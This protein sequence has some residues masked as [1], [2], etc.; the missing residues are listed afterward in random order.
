MIKNLTRR[1]FVVGASLAT[2]AFAAGTAL[3]DAAAPEGAPDAGGPGEGGAPGAGGPGGMGSADPI[4]LTGMLALKQYVFVASQ[5]EVTDG[6]V[7]CECFGAYGEG[8][9]VRFAPASFDGAIEVYLDAAKTQVAD[10]VTASV[11]DGT[12]T[13]EGVSGFGNVTYYLTTGEG[14]YTTVVY[15]VNDEYLTDAA[16]TLADGTSLE[17]SRYAPNMA[18]GDYTATVDAVN[19]AGAVYIGGNRMIRTAADYGIEGDDAAAVD[20]F[21]SSGVTNAGDTLTEFGEKMYGFEYAVALY[22]LF[23]I[24]CDQVTFAKDYVDATDFSG[25]MFSNDPYSDSVSATLQVG[26]WNGIYTKMTDVKDSGATGDYP[27]FYLLTNIDADTT[28]LGTGA[29]VTGKFARVGLYNALQS[30]WTMKNDDGLA[31]AAQLAQAAADYDGAT[32]EA[33]ADYTNEAKVAAVAQVLEGADDKGEAAVAAMD[34]PMGKLDCIRLLYTVSGFVKSRTAPDAA[35]AE[36][37]GSATSDIAQFFGPE[38]GDTVVMSGAVADVPASLISEKNAALLVDDVNGTL[39]ICDNTVSLAGNADDAANVIVGATDPNTARDGAEAA[40]EG[41]GLVYNASARNAFYRYGIGSAMAVWGK[42]SHVK[43][44]STDGRLVVDGEATGSAYPAGTMAG[45]V[46]CGFGASVNVANAVAY[47]SEQHL[48]NILYNGSYHYTDSAA[49]GT[50]RVFSSD[51]WGG[52]QVFEDCVASGDCVTD[53]PT[54]LIVK[55]SVYG[56]SLGG[57]GFASLYFENS[58]V[59]GGC[60]EFQ[61]TTS[62]VTDV[63]AMTVVNSSVECSGDAFASSTKGERAIITLVD[64]QIDMTAGTQ[65]A[66]VD[67]YDSVN[68]ITLASVD[69]ADVDAYQARFNGQLTFKL[70]GENTIATSDGTLGATVAEGATL[71]IFGSVVDESGAAVEIPGAVMETGDEYGTL[72][73]VKCAVDHPVVETSSQPAAGAPA[74]E[75]G[76]APEGGAPA[77]GGAEGGAPE[78]EAPAAGEGGAP[79]DGVPAGD[80]PADVPASK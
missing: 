77:E 38:Y 33:P 76:A 80:A 20:W 72:T 53:E 73:V 75:Q 18:Q 63:A 5:G 79:A 34:E 25:A 6:T 30:A 13:L 21:L 46:Y 51:F 74:G 47:S 24:V 64:S 59:T 10:G 69:P 22:R 50:G 48:S 61:N 1:S 28:M 60:A 17:L 57:N 44:S 67:G 35:W 14:A 58:K 36:Q 62:L 2:C 15:V 31:A 11:A 39:E 55:N 19:A 26:V 23:Q 41:D 78:G 3:A 52:Y 7:S 40:S 32:V 66:R 56:K 27:G 54:T 4:D 9:G 70:Y 12:F 29:Q 65:L 68:A 43:L 49:F 71:T 8:V 42:D 45:A 16:L 37:V